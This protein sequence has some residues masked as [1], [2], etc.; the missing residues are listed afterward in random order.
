MLTPAIRAIVRLHVGSKCFGFWLSRV[1]WRPALARVYAKQ[2]DPSDFSRSLPSRMPTLQEEARIRF[3]ALRQY[4]FLKSVSCCCPFEGEDF[5]SLNV[6]NFA[7]H[8]LYRS[9]YIL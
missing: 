7:H 6:L 2:N 1:R 9:T 5:C 4:H 8:M 3:L